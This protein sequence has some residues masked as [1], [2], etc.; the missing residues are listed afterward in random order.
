[1]AGGTFGYVMAT[2]L[3]LYLPYKIILYG[4]ILLGLAQSILMYLFAEQMESVGVLL[5]VG[6]M[7]SAGVFFTLYL[8]H[9]FAYE[10]HLR[11]TAFGLNNMLARYTLAL[12]AFLAE[13]DVTVNETF[14]GI[15]CLLALCAA[16]ALKVNC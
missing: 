6:T 16:Y 11:A 8:S 7:G 13:C 1:M 10:P 4:S 9:G 5:F 15:Q 3:K 2:F 14:V 12:S